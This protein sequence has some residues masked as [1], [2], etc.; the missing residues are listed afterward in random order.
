MHSGDYIHVFTDVGQALT[1]LFPSLE[2]TLQWPV[3]STSTEAM[4]LSCC[5]DTWDKAGICASGA[6]RFPV[7]PDDTACASDVLPLLLASLWHPSVPLC[8]RVTRLHPCTQLYLELHT[9][10]F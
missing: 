6:A 2:L 8:V 7:N 3:V 1:G 4:S 5:P 10:S 9:H